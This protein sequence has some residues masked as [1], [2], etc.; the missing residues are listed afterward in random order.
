[1]A[2]S[3]KERQINCRV[4]MAYLQVSPVADLAASS[5]IKLS[6]RFYSWQ[7]KKIDAGQLVGQGFLR[8]AGSY[9]FS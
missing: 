6:A 8:Q 7:P 4:M 5:L 3:V 2:T 9:D 1:M